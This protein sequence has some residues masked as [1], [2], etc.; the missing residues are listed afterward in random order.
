MTASP[1][2]TTLRSALEGDEVWLAEPEPVDEPL[3]V[4]VLA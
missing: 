2:T 3:L 4:R 1:P